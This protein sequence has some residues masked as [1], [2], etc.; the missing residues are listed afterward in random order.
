MNINKQRDC[1]LTMLGA[2]LNLE[3]MNFS[4]DKMPDSTVMLVLSGSYKNKDGTYSTLHA[5]E[6]VDSQGYLNV[7]NE[8]LSQL[9]KMLEDAVATLP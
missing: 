9:V 5:T 8:Y 4:I 1:L 2:S 7:L 3:N 6:R